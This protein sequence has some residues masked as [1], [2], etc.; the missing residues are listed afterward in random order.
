M[1]K[2]K[3]NI[4]ELKYKKNLED[5][6]FV[7]YDLKCEEGCNVKYIGESG[8]TTGIRMIHKKAV[9]NREKRSH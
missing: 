5:K 9:K 6:K 1:F 2:D 4:R 7:V 3:R 8:R